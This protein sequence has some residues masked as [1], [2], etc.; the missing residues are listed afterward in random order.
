MNHG[1][2]PACKQTVVSNTSVCMHCGNKLSVNM[3]PD[4]Y[5]PPTNILNAGCGG[6]YVL[7]GILDVGGVLLVLLLGQIIFGLILL[8]LGIA[9]GFWRASVQRKN[10]LEYYYA[11]T[12]TEGDKILS[13]SVNE[14]EAIKELKH[15]LDLGVIT[16]E[17][18]QNK[19]K[20]LLED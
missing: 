9:C 8:A 4:E 14:I 20:K 11:Q 1:R 13:P 3:I 18:F 15:L 6:I 19:K 17:E 2:C 10:A 16:E 12:S 5:R 7:E